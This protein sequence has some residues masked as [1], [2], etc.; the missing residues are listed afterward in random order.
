MLLMLR[1]CK[2]LSIKTFLQLSS[3]KALCFN[4]GNVKNQCHCI[5]VI[6]SFNTRNNDKSLNSYEVKRLKTNRIYL[7]THKE[8]LTVISIKKIEHCRIIRYNML[9]KPYFSSWRGGNMINLLNDKLYNEYYP[10]REE[11]KNEFLNSNGSEIYRMVNYICEFARYELYT[12][13]RK[14]DKEKKSTVS[15]LGTPK[16]QNIAYNKYIDD[17]MLTDKR[18]KN[19]RKNLPDL[20]S[21]ACKI[22]YHEYENIT[23]DELNYVLK[24]KNLDKHKRQIRFFLSLILLIICVCI[25]L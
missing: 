14:Y 7:P 6:R 3:G 21:L 1:K 12:I 20:D 25:F 24:L 5:R 22:M 9:Y 19:I 18:I 4:H 13:K 15:F 10:L 11:E 16:Y 2:Q 8:I 23:A 17:K